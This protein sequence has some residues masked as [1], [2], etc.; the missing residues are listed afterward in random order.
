MITFIKSGGFLTVFV[1]CILSFAIFFAQDNSSDIT[2][3][4]DNRF[5]DL[6][7]SIRSNASQF[8]TDSD[9]SLNILF[10]T[11]LDAGDESASSGG[12]FKVGPL[13][14]AKMIISSFST[15][16]DVIFG[17]TSGFE[18]IPLMFVSL[19]TFIVGYFIVKA[20]IGRDPE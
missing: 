17:G 10:K 3:A 16:F 20:W 5:T 4:N 11:T 2:L 7:T 14:G 12:Q 13:T 15:S 1:I 19:I 18:F 6:N 9:T 8:A